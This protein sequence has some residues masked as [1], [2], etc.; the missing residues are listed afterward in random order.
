MAITYKKALKTI[1][2]YIHGI[3]D[4]VTVADTVSAPNASN[5]YAEFEAGYKMHLVT[6]EGKQTVVPYHAV[7]KVEVT[8]AASENITRNDPFCAE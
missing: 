8:T 2:V 5:A 7:I 4:P 3:N 6:G 1:N